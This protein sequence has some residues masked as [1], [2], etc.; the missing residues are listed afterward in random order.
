MLFVEVLD[1]HSTLPDQR[2]VAGWQIDAPRAGE[3]LEGYALDISGWVVGSQ[4]AVQR[5]EV[6]SGELTLRS[7]D[8]WIPRPDAVQCLE[9]I[10]NSASL[11]KR[12]AGR[13]WQST[14]ATTFAG[15]PAKSGFHIVV[16]PIGLPTNFELSLVAVFADGSR[17]PLALLSGRHAPLRVG[18]TPR[19][20]PVTLNHLGRSGSTWLACLLSEH[21]DVVVHRR[22]PYET[23]VAVH[24]LRLLQTLGT[25]S[26]AVQQTDIQALDRDLSRIG[27]LPLCCQAEEPHSHAWL[28]TEYVERLAAFCLRTI[29]GFYDDVARH[30]QKESAHY[31]CEK[32]FTRP[33]IAPMCREL[34]SGCRTVFLVRDFRDTLCSA[35]A[36]HRKHGRQDRAEWSATLERVAN[37]ARIL[38]DQ[39]QALS[40]RAHLVRY[41]DLVLRPE[42]TLTKL[43]TYLDTK[44]DPDTVHA[45]IERASRNELHLVRHLT[46]KDPRQSIGRWKQDLPMEMQAQCQEA[47]REMLLA[48]DYSPSKQCA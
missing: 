15:D 39:W 22:Y 26:S 18:Y 30:Q 10:S 48:F 19:R 33:L 45:V 29:D 24:T 12:F 27:C 17:A 16:S 37:R 47:L 31:F 14:K 43:F 9:S 41:E 38:A 20:Q 28:R 2:L 8:V 35:Q 44:S 34:Y 42:A 7:A 4:S 5:V 36:F 6:L 40:G 25:P 46:A 32:M 21:P 23:F 3:R 1:V 13:I 11:L